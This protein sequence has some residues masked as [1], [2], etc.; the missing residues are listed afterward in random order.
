MFCL[1]DVACTIGNASQQITLETAGQPKFLD[2]LNKG[3]KNIMHDIFGS[4]RIEVVGARV[5]IRESRRIVGEVQ[6]TAED[7]ISGRIWPDVIAR[8]AYPIDIHSPT[9]ATGSDDQGLQD[10][11]L[12][13]GTT[14]GI[15]YRASMNFLK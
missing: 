4:A 14:Y 5:G 12:G 10:D 6:I 15:P 2:A 11:F 7:V 3:Q 8:S 1:V 9:G 13:K